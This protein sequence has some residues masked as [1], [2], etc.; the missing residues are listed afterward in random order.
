[1][2]VSL[3]NMRRKLD[4]HILF[5]HIFRWSP[6]SMLC[7]RRRAWSHRLTMTKLS[8]TREARAESWVREDSYETRCY[9]VRGTS[10]K[11]YSRRRQQNTFQLMYFPGSKNFIIIILTFHSNT[12]FINLLFSSI[13]PSLIGQGWSWDLK[14]LTSDF[15]TDSLSWLVCG[16]DLQEDLTN[17]VSD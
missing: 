13:S 15:F 10:E 4:W 14:T 11:Y 12:F 8:V 17:I 3:C 2:W 1:M 16:A 9:V 6:Q 5:R 7:I